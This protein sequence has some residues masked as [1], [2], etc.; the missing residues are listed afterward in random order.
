VESGFNGFCCKAG[1]GEEFYEATKTLVSNHALRREMS[2]NARRSAW[3]YERNKILQQM[4]ENYKDAIVNHAD[5]KYLKTLLEQYPEATGRNMLSTLCCQYFIIKRV[6]EPFLDTSARVQDLVNWVSS[7]T[8]GGGSCLP[9]L[10]CCPSSS[11]P[12][13]CSCSCLSSGGACKTSSKEKASGEDSSDEEFAR[14]S[15]RP[16]ARSP[17]SLSLTFFIRAMNF[18]AIAASYIIIALFVYASFTV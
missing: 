12:S 13:S 3:K 5:P 9:A 14:T 15:P 17:M 6:L 2:V 18:F 11:C 4:A 10:K 16:R 7:L 8:Q 1:D